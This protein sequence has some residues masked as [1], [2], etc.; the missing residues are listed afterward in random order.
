[1]FASWT[2]AAG[3]LDFLSSCRGI[4][5]FSSTTPFLIESL[6]SLRLFGVSDRQIKSFSTTNGTRF[7]GGQGCQGYCY[8]EDGGLIASV[9]EKDSIQNQ[10]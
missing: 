2:M 1:M 3:D 6:W 4:L 9:S 7:D 5:R 10:D 8:G